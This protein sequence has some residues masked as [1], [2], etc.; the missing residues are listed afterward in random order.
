MMAAGGKTGVQDVDRV[1]RER[2]AAPGIMSQC[3]NNTSAV[4]LARALG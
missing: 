2:A 4:I 3:L 1:I